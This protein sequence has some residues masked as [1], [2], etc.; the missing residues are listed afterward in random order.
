M[1]VFTFNADLIHLLYSSENPCIRNCAWS[2][3]AVTVMQS[4]DTGEL[5]WPRRHVNSTECMMRLCDP[6][7]ICVQC[8]HWSQL[9][10]SGSAEKSI[11]RDVTPCS[12]VE[13]YKG[14]GRTYVLNLHG[15]IISQGNSGNHG[16]RDQCWKRNEIGICTGINLFCSLHYYILVMYVHFILFVILDYQHYYNSTAP[17]P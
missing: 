8:R 14:F 10:H 6:W 2:C 13:V 7:R 1:Q 5:W 15:Q 3:G 12:L 17:T 9:L 11:F 4:E 16:S